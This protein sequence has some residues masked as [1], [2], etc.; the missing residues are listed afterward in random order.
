MA[1]TTAAK[2]TATPPRRRDDIR[3][4]AGCDRW[5]S[6]R[7]GNLDGTTESVGG[8]SIGAAP[9][10][11]VAGGRA[12]VTVGPVSVGSCPAVPCPAVGSGAEIAGPTGRAVEMGEAAGGLAATA[13]GDTGAAG[14]TAAA[15]RAGGAGRAVAPAGMAGAAGRGVALAVVAGASAQATVRRSATPGAGSLKPTDD[16]TG[17]EAG[18]GGGRF[19]GSPC[20]LG[21]E[22]T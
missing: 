13:G 7:T 4:R 10:E 17:T 1:S 20:P 18:S 12:A 15:G 3:N 8:R 6:C 22:S 5:S 9:A 19:T 14:G 16:R 21:L 2:A 11:A